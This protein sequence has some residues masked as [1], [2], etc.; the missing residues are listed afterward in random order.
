MYAAETYRKHNDVTHQLLH[1][2]L[3]DKNVAKHNL[4]SLISEHPQVKEWRSCFTTWIL[5]QPLLHFWYKTKIINNYGPNNLKSGLGWLAEEDTSLLS[6]LVLEI[7]FFQITCTSHSLHLEEESYIR[8]WIT[9]NITLISS[10][11]WIWTK[12]LFSQSACMVSGL[13]L[14]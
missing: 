10:E 2:R 1:K 13:Q 14:N 7:S 8:S 3:R 12:Q 9:L 4:T 5:L 11:F 6:F